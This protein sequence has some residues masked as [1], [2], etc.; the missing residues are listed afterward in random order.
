MSTI[1]VADFRRFVKQAGILA[2]GIVLSATVIL[3]SS[4]SAG[5]FT[6]ESGADARM[7]QAKI[8][9]AHFLSKATFGPTVADIE[10]LATR[11]R[12]V[13][14]R[15]ACEEWIDDQ[16]AIVDNPGQG[17]LVRTHEET[18]QEML[19]QASMTD[20]FGSTGVWRYRNHAWWDIALRGED[21]LRQRVAWAMSQIFVIGG[22]NFRSVTADETGH[23]RWLGTVRYYDEVLVDGA[24]G[25]Y[26]DV[27]TNMTYSPIMGTY[28][29]HRQNRKAN[30]G[31]NRYPDENYAR[32]IMQLF[33]IGLH[34]LHPDG[35]PMRTPE[36]ELIATY[37]NEDIKSLARLFT[38]MKQN[39]TNTNFYGPQ[40]DNE[41]MIIYPPEHD[42]NRNY[43]DEAGAPEHKR[44]LG[45][46]LTT[47]L[48]SS[49]SS[50]AAN[51][52]LVKTEIDEG[53]DV[54]FN[55]PNVGPFISRLLIQRLVKS[56]PSRAYIRRVAN[57]FN[58][59]G[60]GVR[61]DFRAVVKAILLD[62]ELTRSQRVRRMRAPDRVTVTSRGTESSRLR[63]PLLLITSM[64]RGFNPTSDNIDGY[65]M[66]KFTMDDFGQEPYGAPSVFNFYLPSYQP[67]G[68]LPN[69]QPSRT[70][71][72]DGLSAP[73]FQIMDAVLANESA[74]QIFSWIRSE[75]INTYLYG[76]DGTGYRNIISFDLSAESAMVTDLA[77]V[78]K[79]IEDLD[80]RFCNGTLS[81]ESR[82]A[83]LDG[84]NT[85]LQSNSAA[86]LSYRLHE[87]IIG[88]LTSPDCMIEE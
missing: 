53:L 44:F 10:T 6:A 11:I 40:N 88:V 51:V 56:N 32:E 15:R 87:T 38:G 30:V 25:N 67:A 3:S 5:T 35:R 31:A 80:L 46:T 22:E 18:V 48:P 63:E 84:I 61:G 34:M 8:R 2:I 83:I 4:A 1:L 71:P 69:F 19:V 14:Y 52:E 58:D 60:S 59:N 17:D 41:P 73:E 86:T 62:P 27:L 12:Q 76:L 85:Y 68:A 29:S 23:G 42:N 36:G 78:P 74:N 20:T 55:H 81:D 77:D 47:V 21:Q 65:M 64:V 9:A 57:K 33:S 24:F 45:S 82:A 37:D 79:L 16:F 70:I 75:G 13:G 50:N 26:R 43:S 39:N 72:T 54:I 66:L 7:I 28:L 49:L